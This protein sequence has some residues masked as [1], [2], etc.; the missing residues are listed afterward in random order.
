MKILI[1]A[2]HKII[3][4]GR[5]VKKVPVGSLP[6]YLDKVNFIQ[7]IEYLAENEFQTISLSQL[8]KA[9]EGEFILPLKTVILT[10]DDGD[11]SNYTI[12]YPI[13][14]KYNFGA[15]FFIITDKIDTPGYMT[16]QNVKE[17]S[18]NGMEIGSHTK[19]HAYLP[20]LSE[21]DVVFEFKE[22]KK[23]LEYKLGRPIYFLSIPFGFY[24]TKEKTIAVECGYKAICTSEAGINRFDENYRFNLQRIHVKKDYS[25]KMFTSIVNQKPSVLFKIIIYDR[26]LRILKNIFNYS[27]WM[28]ARNIFLKYKYQRGNRV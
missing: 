5:D 20:S 19:T 25:I 26:L 11:I 24:H 15:T 16:W 22:S 10:F 8:I 3:S 28:R 17:M 14:K 2:Y 9:S 18:D 6:Y 13:F 12:A 1:L 23:T 7:Q 4:E 27:M 21:K